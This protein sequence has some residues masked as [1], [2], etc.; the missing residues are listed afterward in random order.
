M[1]IY[2]FSFLCKNLLYEPMKVY[3]CTF[4][5]FNEFY[6]L[7]L[8]ASFSP[9]GLKIMSIEK[10][11]GSFELLSSKLKLLAGMQITAASH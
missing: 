10:G 8:W 7:T 11:G 9:V 4:K 3:L 5:L 6:S 1:V 2:S